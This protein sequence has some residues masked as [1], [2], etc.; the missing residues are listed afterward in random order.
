M[1]RPSSSDVGLGVDE[2]G[3]DDDDAAAAASPSLRR[4]RKELPERLSL[5]RSD[6]ILL[7]VEG[8]GEVGREEVGSLTDDAVEDDS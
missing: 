6:D 2:R 4:C 1:L 8:A 3:V 7:I 5:P